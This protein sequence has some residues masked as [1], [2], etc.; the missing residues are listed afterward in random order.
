MNSTLLPGSDQDYDKIYSGLGDTLT[1][2][3]QDEMFSDR[4]VKTA[5][6]HDCEVKYMSEGYQQDA[7]GR[8]SPVSSMEHS[9]QGAHEGEE[10]DNGN[11]EDGY[12]P[13]HWRTLIDFHIPDHIQ[14]EL[15][16]IPRLSVLCDD[17]T[18]MCTRLLPST[19][20]KRM[21]CAKALAFAFLT[22]LPHVTRL[23]RHTLPTY[24]DCKEQHELHRSR[25]RR[26]RHLA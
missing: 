2:T 22:L 11:G 7:Q 8:M 1:P 19:N 9:D 20:A 26:V 25:R 23:H 13:D 12:S 17:Y 24:V 5:F 3:S 15:P 10:S 16:S 18:R 6:F 14:C 4:Y 21:Q